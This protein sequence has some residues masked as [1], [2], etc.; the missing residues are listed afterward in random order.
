MRAC[1]PIG[2]AMDDFSTFLYPPLG[3]SRSTL[4]TALIKKLDLGL[5]AL[6]GDQ[7]VH[8]FELARAKATSGSDLGP[9]GAS[10]RT[11]AGPR[12]GIKSSQDPVEY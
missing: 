11:A 10:S 5:V 6:G 9:S 1:L 8:P 7:F 2:P 3:I 4:R 12:V